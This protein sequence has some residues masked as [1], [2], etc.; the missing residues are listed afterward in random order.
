MMSL[1]NDLL[2]F[3]IALLHSY[4]VI[5]V[6][7]KYENRLHAK[8]SHIFSTKNNSVFVFEIDI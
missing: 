2:K 3:Q 1:V 7:K 4:S 5:F 6:E 8:A